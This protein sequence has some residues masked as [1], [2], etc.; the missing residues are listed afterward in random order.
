[1]SGRHVYVNLHLAHLCGEVE[2]VIQGVW[3]DGRV[4][5]RAEYK[6]VEFRDADAAP[7]GIDDIRNVLAQ[8]IER[9]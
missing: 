9:L 8:I 1:M 5:P 3:D 6:H 2:V 4:P 7:E